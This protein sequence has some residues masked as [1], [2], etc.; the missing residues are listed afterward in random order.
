VYFNKTTIKDLI[1]NNNL[2]YEDY[3]F[4]I[5]KEKKFENKYDIYFFDYANIK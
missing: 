5:E 3:Y 4:D 1:K 2:K